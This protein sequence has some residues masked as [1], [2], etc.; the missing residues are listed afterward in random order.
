MHSYTRPLMHS[1]THPLMHSY[2][3]P[4]M[5]SCTRPLMHSYTRPLMHSYTHPLMH[6]YTRPLKHSCTHTLTHSP[7]YSPTYCRFLHHPLPLTY[8][9]QI[10]PRNGTFLHSPWQWYRSDLLLPQ[11]SITSLTHLS[12][13]CVPLRGLQ[14]SSINSATGHCDSFT[15]YLENEAGDH[16][17]Q[18]WRQMLLHDHY[19]WYS[20]RPR[21]AASTIELR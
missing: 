4:L 9:Q 1:Y 17:E 18:L 2:T 7:T 20:A 6:S 12:L 21:T 10:P 3:H 19:V 16:E 15:A 11:A 14:A 8:N 5:H 13:T